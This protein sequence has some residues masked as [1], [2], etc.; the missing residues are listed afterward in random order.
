[1]S[2]FFSLSVQLPT[3]IF[4]S[5]T[6]TH[7]PGNITR[8]SNAKPTWSWGS[9][10]TESAW[11]SCCRY[12]KWNAPHLRKEVVYFMVIT[13]WIGSSQILRPPT[14]IDLQLVLYIKFT[15]SLWLIINWAFK[16]IQ[17]SLQVF[18]KLLSLASTASSQKYQS[19]MWSQML[20]STSGFLKS[21]SN[22]SGK[23]IGPLIKQWVY[24]SNAQPLCGVEIYFLNFL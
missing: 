10:K 5:D 1:M 7:C 21:I 11:N 23:D 2:F 17:I 24:P 20:V 15:I 6:P 3:C 22:V 4:P 18:N 14:P 19:H 8:C 12:R 16:G 9:S 13:S